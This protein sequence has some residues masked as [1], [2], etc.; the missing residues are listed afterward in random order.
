[1]AVTRPWRKPHPVPAV[2]A[3]ASAVGA[4]VPEDLAEDLAAGVEASAAEADAAAR[5][6][7]LEVPVVGAVRVDSPDA[8]IFLPRPATD[9]DAPDKLAA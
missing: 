3:A 4:E 1:M 7:D 6:V 9:R 2:S 8:E 5:V